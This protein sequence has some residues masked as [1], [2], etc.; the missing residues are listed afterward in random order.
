MSLQSILNEHKWHHK[1]LDALEITIRHRGG[2]ND[3]RTI[4]GHAIL[5][6]R[7]AGFTAVSFSSQV[8][9][10]V[11]IPYHRILSVYHTTQS[12]TIWTR[13]E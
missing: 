13:P 6:V 9:D 4:R 2:P 1:D 3:M 8:D 5:E 11:W 7:P 10:H 12:K